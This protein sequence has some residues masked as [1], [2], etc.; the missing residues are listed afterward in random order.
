LEDLPDVVTDL[1]DTFKQVNDPYVTERL[2]AVAYGCAM[3]TR[4]PRVAKALA[5]KT[6]ELIFAGGEPPVNILTRDY[7]RG[8]IERAVVLDSTSS[9]DMQKVR[10]PYGSEWPGDLPSMKELKN[11][12]ES[13]EN[14][15]TAGLGRILA[16][17]TVDDFSRYVIGTNSHSFEWSSERLEGPDRPSYE[18]RFEEFKQELDEGQSQR[19]EKLREIRQRPI[20]QLLNWLNEGTDDENYSKDDLE[21]ELGNLKTEF[22]NSLREEQQETFDEVVWPY[23]ENPRIDDERTRLD[24]S[25]IQRFILQRILE[26]GYTDDLFQDFDARATNNR[27]YLRS[28]EKPERIGKKYQWIAYYEA[29]ARVADNFKFSGDGW[30]EENEPFRGPWQIRMMRNIDPSVVASD[31]QTSYFMDPDLCW[32]FDPDYDWRLDKGLKDW[33]KDESNVPSARSRLEVVREADKTEWIILHGYFRWYEDKAPEDLARVDNVQRQVWYIVNSYLLPRALLKDSFEWARRYDF[34]QHDG[35]TTRPPRPKEIHIGHCFLGE[36]FWS[37]C[38]RSQFVFE[39]ESNAGDRQ[40]QW[41]QT[42]EDFLWG[43]VYDCSGQES[44]SVNVPAN[45]IVQQMGLTWATKAR[46]EDSLGELIA[47]DPS[48]EERG[49]S[50]LLVRKDELL[51]FL[52]Q[53]NLSLIWT[54]KGEKLIAGGGGGAVMFNKRMDINGAYTLD[55]DSALV[56][57]MSFEIR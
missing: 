26:L 17:V 4:D 43:R 5:D 40:K 36:L 12:Y 34:T 13:A 32:W 1:L 15:Y 38:Y 14:N 21:E 29:L 42:T 31:T 7:A 11:K 20:S 50:M 19:L 18:D 44:V 46:Y 41:V 23:I 6:Y 51:S 3:R 33:L 8:I 49:P 57:G 25:L 54:I 53:N 52:N 28:G 27:R 39:S 9:Y 35:S 48:F 55:E 45:E 10:P 37:P 24:L 22:C 2:Y 47:W 30:N 16:S 56:G